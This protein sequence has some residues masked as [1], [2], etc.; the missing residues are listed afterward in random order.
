MLFEAFRRM[1]A[2]DPHRAAFLVTT[3]DRSLPITCS[4]CAAA[5]VSPFTSLMSTVRAPAPSPIFTC[6]TD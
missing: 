6:T 4:T 2:E 1:R 5:S 3:G